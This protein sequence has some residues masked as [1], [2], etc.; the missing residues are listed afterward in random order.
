ML[1]AVPT[2]IIVVLVAYYLFVGVVGSLHMILEESSAGNRAREDFA[3]WSGIEISQTTFN[4]AVIA[5]MSIF[6]LPVLI[7][8]VTVL[9]KKAHKRNGG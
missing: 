4:I 1:E 3:K 9:L 5:V 2:F 8:C 7:Y 6:W